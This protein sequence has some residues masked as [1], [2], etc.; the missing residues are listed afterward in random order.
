MPQ[1]V[2]NDTAHMRGSH[3]GQTVHPTCPCPQPH[4]PAVERA[5]LTIGTES[6]S[7]P[8]WYGASQAHAPVWR[9]SPPRILY[10]PSPS[11]DATELPGHANPAVRLR[12]HRKPWITAP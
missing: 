11:A 2:P 3:P 7:A 9:P 6:A 4:V 12:D 5:P 10:I 1:V 8:C